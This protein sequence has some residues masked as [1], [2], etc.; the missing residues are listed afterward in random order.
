MLFSFN[1]TY[2]IFIPLIS[3]VTIERNLRSRLEFIM[4]KIRKINI[5]I[6]NF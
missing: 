3:Q 2:I 1:F 5:M 6:R 4:L